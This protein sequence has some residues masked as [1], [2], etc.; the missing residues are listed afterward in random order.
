MDVFAEF[1]YFFFSL[2]VL[3]DTTW[4]VIL[5]AER[6]VRAPAVPTKILE[7]FTAATTKGIPEGVEV[8]SWV[9]SMGSGSTERL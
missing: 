4:G 2:W 7:E 5:A 1:L 6:G 3:Y 9:S 8:P